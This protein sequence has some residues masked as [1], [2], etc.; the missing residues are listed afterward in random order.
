MGLNAER[1]YLI[2]ER[3]DLNEGLSSGT[4]S[5]GA[6]FCTRQALFYVPADSITALGTTV[7]HTHTEQAQM[8]TLEAL[9][10]RLAAADASLPAI[11]GWL[12]AILADQ[13]TRRVYPVH[14]LKTFKVQVGF[15]IIGG[16]TL[17]HRDGPRQVLNLQPRAA[18]QQLATFY[19]SAL[20]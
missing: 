2:F 18:R 15:W 5:K 17:T 3:V 16:V 20:T 10:N 8:A 1:D 12:Q 19:A 14:E 6:L 9:R 4:I 7:T 11:E 13:P